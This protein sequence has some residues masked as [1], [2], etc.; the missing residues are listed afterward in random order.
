MV[1][2]IKYNR[3]KGS[4]I[5]S[6][7]FLKEKYFL[8]ISDTGIGM[9]E[10]QLSQIFNRFSRINSDQEGQG[11]GLAIV[12][13]IANFHHI[14]IEVTSVPSEGTTFTFLLSNH[15]KLN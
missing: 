4:I 11:L 1:N 5:I 12:H 3:K 9:E 13:S 6:D 8:S 2:A 10:S 15:R 14:N 7:G